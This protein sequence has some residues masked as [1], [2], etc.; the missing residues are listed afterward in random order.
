MTANVKRKRRVAHD[1]QAVKRQITVVPY[2]T[3]KVKIGLL[4]TP[5]APRM[6]ADAEAIQAGLMGWPLSI[7]R[8]V[9]DWINRSPWSLA[10]AAL[11][12]LFLISFMKGCA[13]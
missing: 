8:R 12:V 13:R 11:A 1:T 4:Y 5:P 2:D 7:E 9:A 10:V 6:D 3:G